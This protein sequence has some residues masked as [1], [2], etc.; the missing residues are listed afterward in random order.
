MKKEEI[1]KEFFKL[2]SEGFSYA[3]CKRILKVKCQYDA[4]IRTLKRWSARLNN[5]NWD[6][7]DA[8]R[9]PHTIHYKVDERLKGEVLDLRALTGW[10]EDKLALHFPLSHTTINSILNEEGLCKDTK[11]RVS[12]RD[13]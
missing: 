6:L 3:Q 4:S 1:R 8:S 10:G 12:E 7:M 11:N 5:E 2:K 13:G 9:K